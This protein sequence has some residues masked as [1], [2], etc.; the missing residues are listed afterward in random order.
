MRY[1]Y[2]GGGSNKYWEI[3]QPMTIND[4]W[5]VDVR[6]GRIGTSGQSH[7]K[8]FGSKWSADRY[9]DSKVEEKL[10]KGYHVTGSQGAKVPPSTV[11]KYI[12]P[13]PQ[14]PLSVGFTSLI[15]PKF[16]PPKPKACE[17]TTLSRKGGNTWECASC[18]H[19]VEFDKAPGAVEVAKPEFETRVRRFF[20]SAS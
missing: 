7:R 14:P 16:S 15:D 19:K 8:V 1:E 5:V 17:H 13:G 2:R 10:R 20:A 6:F 4:D 11:P 12:Q 18:K 3:F 9:Y